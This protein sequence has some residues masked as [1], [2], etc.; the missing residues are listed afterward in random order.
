MKFNI[1]RYPNRSLRRQENPLLVVED[2]DHLHV[3]LEKM[4][5][6]SEHFL[7]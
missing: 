5:R 1:G 4:N 2:I 3:V 6:G 7:V